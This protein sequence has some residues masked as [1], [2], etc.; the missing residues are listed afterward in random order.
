M[1]DWPQRARSL[2]LQDQPCVAVTVAALRGSAPREAG[3]KMLITADE[4]MGSIGGGYLELE[5]TRLARE[6]LRN[7]GERRLQRFALGSECGQCCGGAVQIVFAPIGDDDATWLDAVIARQ[8]AGLASSIVTPLD[9]TS[10]P[11]TWQA[12]ADQHPA[13]LDNTGAGKHLIECATPA[14]LRLT[15]FGAGHVGRAVARVFG[16][17]DART[18]IIDNRQAQLEGSWPHNVT[19]LFIDAPADYVAHSG[20]GEQYLVMTHDHDL[21]FAI[22]TALLQR[23]DA[24][25]IGLIGS[26]TK[27]RRFEKRWR[28][29]DIDDAAIAQLTCP[30]GNPDIVGKHPGEIA[31]ATAADIL[32]RRGN[33]RSNLNTTLT[34][35]STTTA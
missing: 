31:I 20:P 34:L 26:A 11:V 15:I 8:Q 35:V 17:L 12:T 32:A 7:G 25:F 33:Q 22:C 27:R 13:R 5:C 1:F 23:G 10:A 16:T 24:A 18:L 19:P 29:V 9:D 6:L 14:P 3:S 30:I 4:Q 21:D 2:L 28:A